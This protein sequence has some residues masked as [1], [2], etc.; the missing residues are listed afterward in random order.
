MAISVIPG[1]KKP[2]LLNTQVARRLEKRLRWA[3]AGETFGQVVLQC[4][5]NDY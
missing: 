1:K 2:E 3:E 4:P 5:Q